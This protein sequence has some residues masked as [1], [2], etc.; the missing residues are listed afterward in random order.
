[1]EEDQGLEYNERD[2]EAEEEAEVN[3]MDSDED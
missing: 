3:P 2:E 1:M